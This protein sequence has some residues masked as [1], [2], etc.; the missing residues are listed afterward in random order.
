MEKKL[1][2]IDA[3]LREGNHVQARAQLTELL[4]TKI[5]RTSLCEVSILLRRAG[6]YFASAKILSPL[7]IGK[8]S[9]K[10]KPSEKEKAEYAAALNALG[11]THE[12][13]DLLK[14][15]DAKAYPKKLLYEAYAHMAEWE[16]RNVVE[17]L[18]VYHE[19]ELTPYE[20]VICDLNMAAALIHEGQ[21]ADAQKILEEVFEI[22][23]KENIRTHF[24]NAKALAAANFIL[25]KQWEEAEKK[26]DEAE[27]ALQNASELE[28]FFVTKWRAVLGILRNPEDAT[29]LKFI[30]EVRKHAETLNHAESLRD[31]DRY[32]SIATKDAE[33]LHKVY[34][35]TPHENFRNKLVE[36]SGTSLELPSK[37][38]FK[39]GKGA[40]K[41]LFIDFSQIPDVGCGTLS[42][43]ILLAL[44]SDFYSPVSLAALHAK[45]YPGEHFNPYSSP[46]RIYT[47]IHRVREILEENKVPI[48]IKEKDGSY[49][50]SANVPVEI[51]LSTPH[52]QK[53]RDSVLIDFLKE[54]LPP[55]PFSVSEAAVVLNLTPRSALRI[56][57][58]ALECHEVSKSGVGRG[59]KYAFPDAA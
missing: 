24:G 20:K 51:V 21:H 45:V 50:L 33:L 53:S 8:G 36:R 54:K 10:F 26:L 31:L 5:P 23:K 34:F 38:H 55:R 44:V 39:L 4:A 35:G 46:T 7:F 6:Q 37:Y 18:K 17:V 58:K 9:D 22:A 12:A 32:E 48:E 49:I 28:K 2:I 14:K 19:T 52:E 41:A 30:R 59:T 16:T 27:E 11:A 40:P 43:R 42:H 56:L 13:K 15:V 1:Q 47:A 25:A 29:A 57:T 3:F